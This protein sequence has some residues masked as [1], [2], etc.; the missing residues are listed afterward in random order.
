[1]CLLINTL[2]KSTGKPNNY[3]DLELG[4]STNIF[5]DT[6]DTSN[7]IWKWLSQANA[8]WFVAVFIVEGNAKLWLEVSGKKC[9]FFFQVMD[10]L[11]S[12]RGPWVCGDCIQINHSQHLVLFTFWSL[13]KQILDIKVSKSNF[14]LHLS[15]H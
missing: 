5:W 4:S 12:S 8:M 2:I 7:F 14:L 11:S 9:Y 10:R 3:Y 6:G 15:I 1:M 13:N